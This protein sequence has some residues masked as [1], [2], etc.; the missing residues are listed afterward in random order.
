MP[1]DYKVYL[2]DIIQAIEKI[3]EYTTEASYKEFIDNSM[4]IDATIRNLE[5]IGEAVKNISPDVRKRCPEV[6]W[7]KIA[8]LRDILIHTYFGVNMEIIWDIVKNK[9]PELVN[10]IRKL[11]KDD[12]SN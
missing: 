3:E 2:D 12:D 9:L 4:M 7:K 6:E 10:A 5:I 1:K 8:G 11:A